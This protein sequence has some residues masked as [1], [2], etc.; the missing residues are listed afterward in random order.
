MGGKGKAELVVVTFVEITTVTETR[1]FSR[2][3]TL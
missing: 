2:E 1:A 3:T